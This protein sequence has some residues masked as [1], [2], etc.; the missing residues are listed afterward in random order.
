M[1]NKVRLRKHD[2]Q[3]EWF[4]TGKRKYRLAKKIADHNNRRRE[5]IQLM[6]RGIFVP[7]LT[8]GAIR[9]IKGDAYRR[10]LPMKQRRHL[11]EA[12]LKHKRAGYRGIIATVKKEGG[13]WQSFIIPECKFPQYLK[14]NNVVKYKD[15]EGEHWLGD[16]TQHM[17]VI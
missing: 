13:H 11:F 4:M 10:K 5:V 6:F 2:S 7:L 15:A 8:A 9:V 12:L 1:N 17:I 16:R 3:P 14:D